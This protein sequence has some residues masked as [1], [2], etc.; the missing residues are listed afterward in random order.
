MRQARRPPTREVVT[1]YPGASELVRDKEALSYH[2]LLVACFVLLCVDVLP[3]A[4]FMVLGLCSYVRNFQA[5]HEACH[6]RR[7]RDN[8]L[9]RLRFLGMIVN[10][11]L[12]FGRDQLVRDHLLH[13]EH[14]GDP[15][16]DPDAALNALPWTTAVLHA[17]FQPELG[18]ISFVRRSG[19][20]SPNLRG[21]LAY[22]AVVFAALVAFAG[23]DIVWW[24]A[25]TRLG[26]LA[27]W[28]IFDWVLHNPRVWAHADPIPVPIREANLDAWLSPDPGD[29]AAQYAILD[30][31][32]RPYYEHRE[33][34]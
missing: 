24:I 8:P 7:V 26:S 30:D 27:C 5:L 13:H 15:V 31:R 9:R 3:P 29:L 14:V 18:L 32:E 19:Y 16:R 1:R 33:A 4:A 10:S 2:A 25:V 11:P 6:T 34:A 23:A 21:V 12:Q 22:N 20:I 17:V 28:F